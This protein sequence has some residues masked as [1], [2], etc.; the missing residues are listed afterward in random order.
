MPKR[1]GHGE[2][3]IEQRESDGRWCASVDLG[4]ANGKH[5]RKVIYGKTRKEVA[6]KLL[7]EVV[8]TH[9]LSCIHPL[10]RH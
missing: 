4:F 5:R 3:G 8:I 10:K 9:H 1:R 6:D 2:G 7:S